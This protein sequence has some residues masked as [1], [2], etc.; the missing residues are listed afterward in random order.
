MKNSI[1]LT[2][3]FLLASVSVFA[4]TP[5]KAA[6]VPANDVITFSTLASQKGVDIKLEKGAAQKAIVIITDKDGN[7]IR[8]DALS[9]SKGLEKAYILNQLEYGD[10]TI[11]V[12]ANNQTIKK[13]IHVYDE[14]GV[15]QFIV[16]Q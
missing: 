2:A 5:S 12:A 16:I 3:L 14:N 4:V 15:K 6:V 10:Y 8:K 7:V 1:K 11:E 13:D 9:N